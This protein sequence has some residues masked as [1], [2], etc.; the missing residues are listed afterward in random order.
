MDVLSDH[1][2]LGGNSN[3][4]MHRHPFHLHQEISAPFL[5]RSYERR[6]LH[7][8]HCIYQVSMYR[9]Q[10]SHSQLSQTPIPQSIKASIV[11]ATE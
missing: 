5:L 6:L 7:R 11:S 2:K 10:T 1:H 8:N 9:L 3:R 4:R